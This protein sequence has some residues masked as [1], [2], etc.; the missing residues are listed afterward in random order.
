M[1]SSLDIGTAYHLA[2]HFVRR[3]KTAPPDILKFSRTCP[4]S[5]A[6]FAYSGDY[7]LNFVD[8]FKDTFKMGMMPKTDPLSAG[9]V[10]SSALFLDELHRNL[11]HTFFEY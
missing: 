8:Y 3:W 7:N 1:P 2:G 4:A 6:N 10:T 5:L 11:N 9:V